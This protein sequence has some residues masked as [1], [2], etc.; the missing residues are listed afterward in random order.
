M[1]HL[2]NTR[3]KTKATFATK[4]A[5]WEMQNREIFHGIKGFFR[6]FAR[7]MFNLGPRLT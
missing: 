7:I 5:D 4:S 1:P 3:T 6:G 2:L